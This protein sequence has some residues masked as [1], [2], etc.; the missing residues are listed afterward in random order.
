MRHRSE[1]MQ[2]RE[3]AETR[4]QR[5]RKY[6]DT[7]WTPAAAQANRNKNFKYHPDL[8]ELIERN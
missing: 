5:A 6:F 4:Q 3:P 1:K 7:L 8:C 2:N